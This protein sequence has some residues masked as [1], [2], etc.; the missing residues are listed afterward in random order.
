MA[1]APRLHR[2]ITT[3]SSPVVR[4]RFMYRFMRVCHICKRKAIL[5]YEGECE[6]CEEKREAR[7]VLRAV[8][9][10]IKSPEKTKG[11]T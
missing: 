2:G 10:P 6:T 8:K 11:S 7:K 4:T 1:T 9:R 3:G 5:N